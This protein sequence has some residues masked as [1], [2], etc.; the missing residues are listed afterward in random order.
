MHLAFKPKFKISHSLDYSEA[1][2][3]KDWHLS[4]PDWQAHARADR[5][6]MLAQTRI[7]RLLHAM[8]QYDT[9]EEARLEAERKARKKK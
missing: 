9:N 7:E 6:Y 5:A 8:Y 3:M 2:A 1:S 4:P